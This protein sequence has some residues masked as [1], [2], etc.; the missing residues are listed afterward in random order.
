LASKARAQEAFNE[1]VRKQ[2]VEA[3]LPSVVTDDMFS[4]KQLVTKMIDQADDVKPR[5]CLRNWDQEL[6][7]IAPEDALKS[8]R[9]FMLP[10]AHCVLYDD[11]ACLAVLFVDWWGMTDADRSHDMLPQDVVRAYH[12]KLPPGRYRMGCTH[13][14]AQTV[15]LD[16]G[17]YHWKRC[18]S[19]RAEPYL[20]PSNVTD[21]RGSA[22]ERLYVYWAMGVPKQHKWVRSLLIVVEE[23]KGE[24]C[25]KDFSD[26][27]KGLD[28]RIHNLRHH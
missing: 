8:W 28:W 27:F 22:F 11:R 14:K 23:A 12:N 9:T 25:L 6:K 16:D 4:D 2:S 3:P 1:A 26:V 19:E 5:V 20:V 21:A 13:H 17:E 7:L 18:H 15:T 10:L 24:L